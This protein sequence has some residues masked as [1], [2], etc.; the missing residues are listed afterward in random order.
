MD[1]SHDLDPTTN[2]D[3]YRSSPY[4]STSNLHAG[5][6]SRRKPEKSR[7]TFAERSTIHDSPSG[8]YAARMREM[9]SNCDMYL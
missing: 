6:N 1:H 2:N 8:E 7:T 5:T 9:V 3:L 4:N